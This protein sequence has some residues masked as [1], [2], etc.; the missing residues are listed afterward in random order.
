MEEYVS[1][2]ALYGARAARGAFARSAADAREA[3]F[4]FD[5]LFASSRDFRFS[6]FSLMPLSLPLFSPLRHATLMPIIFHY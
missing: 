6:P 3:I 2:G 5:Y 1:R 4:D